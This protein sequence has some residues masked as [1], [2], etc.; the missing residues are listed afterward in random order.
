MQ[1]EIM[2][3]IPELAT[4]LYVA[5]G[6]GSNLDSEDEANGYVDYVYIETYIYEDRSLKEY[7]GGQLMLTE[8]FQAKYDLE[9]YD[10]GE[11]EDRLIMDAM[12]FMFEDRNMAYVRIKEG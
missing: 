6:N 3:Y 5:E 9:E 12:D 1:N 7:D 2:V 4:F 10:D 8:S 11:N